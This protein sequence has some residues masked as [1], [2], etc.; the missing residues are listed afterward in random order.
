MLHFPCPEACSMQAMHVP[1]CCQGAQ[2]AR[3]ELHID[4]FVFVSAPGSDIRQYDCVHPPL[5]V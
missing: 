1:G 2:A 4:R 3:W 5:Q